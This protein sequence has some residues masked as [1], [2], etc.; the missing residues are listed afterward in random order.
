MPRRALEGLLGGILRIFFRRIEV[1]GAARVPPS[2]PVLFA[3]NHP[4]ALVDPLLLLC[5]APRPVSFLAKAPLFR[6]P[7]IGWFARALDSIPVHRPQDPGTDPARNRETFAR[8]RSLLDRGGTL[9]IAPEGTSHSDPHLRP[10]RTGAARIAL[11][12]GTREP[13]RIVPVGLFYTAPGTFRS[14]ALVVFGEPLTVPPAAP[15]AA[16]EPP[17][18]RVAEVTAE[19]ERALAA[20]VLQAD[21]LEA[22]DLAARVE[23][24]LTAGPDPARRRSVQDALAIRRR[25]VAGHQL[26]RERAPHE[27][28]AIRDR[29]V[30]LE[31]EFAREGLEPRHLNAGL[32]SPAAVLRGAAR[33]LGRALVFLPLALPGL[34]LHYPAYRLAGLLARRY[35]GP[36]S[37]VTATAKILAAAALFPATWAGAGLAVGLAAGFGPG[38]AVAAAG[39]VAGHAALRL[40]ERLE[41]FRTVARALGLY[42]LEADT[43]ARLARAREQFQEDLLALAGRLGV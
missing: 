5:H 1:A 19:L 7:L 25:L 38:L 18:D 14:E 41:R 13:V 36:A 23:R 6:M 31:A 22:L 34:L 27:L 29:A 4:N 20:V 32:F 30:R 24:L 2:G 10:L 8:A 37:D 35:A 17:P 42:L 43:F 3:I 9:A 40:V 26:L 21:E 16:G 12:A 15:G 39:P 33:F 11:G 28:A